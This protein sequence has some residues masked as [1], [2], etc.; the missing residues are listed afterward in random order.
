MLHLNHI[1]PTSSSQATGQ[2]FRRGRDLSKTCNANT[3]ELNLATYV[4]GLY[5]IRVLTSQ[6]FS[7]TKSFSLIK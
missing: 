2:R 1:L 7:D 6:G 3:M 4:E 5:K